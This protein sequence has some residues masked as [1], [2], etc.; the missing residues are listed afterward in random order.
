MKKSRW[1]LFAAIVFASSFASSHVVRATEADND[2]LS[3]KVTCQTATASAFG[4]GFNIDALC[5]AGQVVVTGGYQCTDAGGNLVEFDVSENT[6]HFSN[7]T[8]DGWQVIG[9]NTGLIDA[10]CRVCATCTK[11]TGSLQ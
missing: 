1:V 10:S 8:P 3:L 11:G 7:V 6:F 4:G 9:T 5:K 2:A